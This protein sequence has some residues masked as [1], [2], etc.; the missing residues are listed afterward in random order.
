MDT[1]KYIENMEDVG[2]LGNTK[3]MEYIENMED[4]K[5][6]MGT[7]NRRTQKQ[8]GHQKAGRTW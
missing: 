1:T 6:T 3:N 7:K 4:L 5:N 2:N 8:R